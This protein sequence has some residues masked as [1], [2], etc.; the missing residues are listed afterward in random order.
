VKNKCEGQK[1][2][3]STLSDAELWAKW[4]EAGRDLMALGSPNLK[5]ADEFNKRMAL[6]KALQHEYHMRK[7][8]RYG[9]LLIPER[10]RK[11]YHC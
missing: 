6:V 4:N 5:N 1:L 2:D 10:K 11:T 7:D 8:L 3:S 9:V